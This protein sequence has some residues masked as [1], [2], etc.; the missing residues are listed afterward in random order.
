MTHSLLDHPKALNYIP[1][2]DLYNLRGTD[3]QIL[4]NL[5]NRI[6]E[7]IITLKYISPKVVSLCVHFPGM[8]YSTDL[9][10]YKYGS[11]MF[12]GNW[13]VRYI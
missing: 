5:D 7:Q 6:G 10:W 8:R 4:C 1:K 12:Y 3:V 13:V 11:L 2:E 9:M